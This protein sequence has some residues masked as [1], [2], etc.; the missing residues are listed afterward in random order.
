MVLNCKHAKLKQKSKIWT[1]GSQ[2]LRVAC[3]TTAMFIT[4]LF[5]YSLLAPCLHFFDFIKQIHVE[6]L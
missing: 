3:F 1:S 6:L 4:M 5:S 2:L